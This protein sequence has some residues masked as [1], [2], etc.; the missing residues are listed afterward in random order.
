[1]VNGT[2]LPP[3]AFA[4]HK[5]DHLLKRLGVLGKPLKAVVSAF[6]VH[7]LTSD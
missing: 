7:E 2:G 3:R 4:V 5:N 6:E 1:M